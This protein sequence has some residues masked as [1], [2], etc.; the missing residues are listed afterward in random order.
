MSSNLGDYQRIVVWAKKMGGPKKLLVLVS[1]ISVLAWRSG[2]SGY[3]Y[4]KQKR[5]KNATSHETTSAVFVVTSPGSSPG[6][7]LNHGDQFRVLASHNDAI[8]IERLG[9][10]TNPYMVSSSFLSSVS[11]YPNTAL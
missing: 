10:N 4:L 3:K 11:N 2:E 5:M 8:L 7:S 6:L 9:D 1:G